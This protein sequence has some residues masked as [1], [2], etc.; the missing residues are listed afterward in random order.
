MRVVAYGASSDTRVP[1]SSDATT[2]DARGVVLLRV[3]V[4][5]FD[6]RD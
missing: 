4:G 2:L 6:L 3:D 5:L 1:A